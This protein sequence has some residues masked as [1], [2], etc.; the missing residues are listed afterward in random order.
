MSAVTNTTTDLLAEIGLKPEQRPVH[1]AVIMD[2]NG[3]W[4]IA[5]AQKSEVRKISTHF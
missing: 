4:A 3:R 2:G 1:I 5:T